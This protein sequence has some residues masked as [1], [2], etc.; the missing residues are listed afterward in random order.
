MCVH[1]FV[2]ASVYELDIEIDNAVELARE[3]WLGVSL[4]QTSR[5]NLVQCY[6]THQ[7]KCV[8]YY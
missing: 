4:P 3:I 7:E 5:A 2:A 1:V 8:R 6:I